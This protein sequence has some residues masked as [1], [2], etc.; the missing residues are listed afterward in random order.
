MKALYQ[1]IIICRGSSPIYYQLKIE[2]NI[3]NFTIVSSPIIAY[4][5]CTNNIHTNTNIIH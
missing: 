5:Y 3:F 1:F 2:L 4:T